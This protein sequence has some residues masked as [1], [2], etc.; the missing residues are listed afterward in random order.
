M[1]TLPQTQTT[2]LSISDEI[3]PNF[4]QKKILNW[5]KPI[6][7]G[8]LTIAFPNKKSF[9]IIGE[10]AGFAADIKINNL[11]FFWRLFAEGEIGFGRAYM[12][13]DWQSED[14]GALLDFALDNEEELQALIKELP[15]VRFFHDLRHKLNANS[16]AGSRKNISYHYDIGNEFYKE[17]LDAS[18]T[19]SSAIFDGQKDLE[20]A[21]IAKYQRIINMLE[22]GPNDRV[23]EIGCGWGGFAEQAITQTGCHITGL[24]LSIEQLEWA[25]NRLAAKGLSEKADLKLLDYRDCAGKFDKIVS[26][27]MLEAV[28]EENWPIYF[29]KLRELLKPNGKAM[30]QSILIENSRFEDYRNDT[31]FIQTYIFP[32]GMLPSSE[33]VNQISAKFGFEMIDEFNFGLDYERTL[34]LWDREFV[35]K[36][37]RLSQI[38]FDDRFY[39]MWRYYLHY[40]AAGFRA[41]RIDVGQ[42]LLKA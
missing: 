33:K 6:K 9:Q 10:K 12:E 11:R 31:D 40:C 14:L 22:I 3:A 17:W 36:W 21:Q 24:T 39:N 4:W 20:A 23:L 1:T 8:S 13:N 16:K 2:I 42:F 35:A 32:G 27:E 18:M 41:K 26:I 19:Y 29:A 37:P 38:G 15:L 5:F 30:I 34:L 28:G 25:N 7:R